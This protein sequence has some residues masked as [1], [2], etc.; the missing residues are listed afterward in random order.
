LSI[1]FRVDPIDV[2]TIDEPVV[3]GVGVERVGSVPDLEA[4]E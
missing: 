4:V 3:V 1:A 2:L